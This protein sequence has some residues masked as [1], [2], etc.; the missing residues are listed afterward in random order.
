MA[1]MVD[2][3]HLTDDQKALICR[4]YSPQGEAANT[5]RYSCECAT[6]ACEKRLNST[7]FLICTAGAVEASAQSHR[8]KVFDW[9][10]EVNVYGV[11]EDQQEGG[12]AT[13]YVQ[14]IIKPGALALRVGDKHQGTGGTENSKEALAVHHAI[15]QLPF[16]IKAPC[17]MSTPQKASALFQQT[18]SATADFPREI[19]DSLAT[20][21][22]DKQLDHD[23]AFPQE[24]IS[25]DMPVRF[26]RRDSVKKYIQDMW[27]E[28]QG[29]DMNHP[30]GKLVTLSVL[31]SAN[32]SPFDFHIALDSMEM[33]GL[34]NQHAWAIM[35]PTSSRVPFMLYEVLGGCL[36]KELCEMHLDGTY[37]IGTKTKRTNCEV[38]TGFRYVYWL[39]D[40]E[41]AR[42]HV[43][44]PKVS[45]RAAIE[46]VGPHHA[47]HQR[48]SMSRG[49]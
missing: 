23:W 2:R 8:T 7:K 45:A 14:S 44:D 13:A 5:K 31:A 33:S 10:V 3:L 36:Y 40:A 46:P 30:L 20:P 1:A 41:G 32:D 15:V 47:A 42:D 29:V 35:L 49:H 11:D 19:F 9:V 43:H 26:K 48:N 39:H 27:N 28:L 17:P 21:A 18:I 37:T 24:E 25:A 38:P 34:A 6:T 12:T 16:G 22:K 4:L